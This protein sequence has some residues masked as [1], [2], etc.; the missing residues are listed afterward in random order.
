MPVIAT[1]VSG[2]GNTRLLWTLLSLLLLPLG[3]LALRRFPVLHDPAWRVLAGFALVVLLRAQAPL[4]PGE[5]AGPPISRF[6]QALV[7]ATLA[8]AL[9]WR[10]GGFIQ[11]ELTAA[12]VQL[13]FLIGG[14]LLL[15]EQIV[16]RGIVAVD[17]AILLWASGLFAVSGVLAV[18]LAR[19]DAADAVA[20]GGGRALAILATLVPIALTLGM[21]AVL[22]PS[23][24]SMIWLGAARALELAL[25]PLLLLLSWLASLLPAGGVPADLRN[26]PPLSVPRPDMEALARQ[27]MPPEWF[28]SLAAMLVLL[29]VLAIA[30]AALKLLL[31]SELVVRPPA[32]R[33]APEP[34]LSVERSGSAGEDARRLLGSLVR[35]LRR[36]LTRRR[37]ERVEATPAT[38]V[39]MD[40]WT[41]YRELLIWAEKRGVVRQPSETAQELQRRL[42]DRAPESTDVVEL[43]TSAFEW[44]RYGDRPVPGERW[45]RLR[46]ALRDLV[47]RPRQ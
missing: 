34:A 26:T 16:F 11:S 15:T 3:Y 40:A 20:L 18:V 35:W 45:T 27:Q 1:T 2:E 19:Q 39:L 38:Q 13:E 47:A 33:P 30:V 9:W 41:A 12:D 8:F 32:R 22:R 17:A 24:L 29:V 44:Q 28:A 6:V 31:D 42:A 43:V 7:P 21:L 23:V 14:G 10:G 36:R 5:S 25:L 46:S 4:A 37:R